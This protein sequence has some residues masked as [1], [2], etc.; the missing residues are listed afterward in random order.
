MKK[1]TLRLTL[2]FAF[3]GITLFSF[4]AVKS[5]AMETRT[6][7]SINVSFD[8]NAKTL[9][10]NE[11]IIYTNNYGVDLNKLVLHLY[12]N[13]YKT[14]STLPSIG[15]QNSNLSEDQ[16]GYIKI[17]EVHVDN[18]AMPF[19]SDNQI[20]KIS[21]DSPLESGH[22]VTLK[23]SFIVKIPAGTD[24]LGYNNDVYSITNWY[25]IM[26]IYDKETNSWDENEFNPVGESNYSDTSDYSFTLVTPKDIVTAATGGILNETISG[27]IK[28][29]NA[30]AY[31]VRDF[32]FMMSRY[33]RI[34]STTSNGVKFKS[35]YIYDDNSKDTEPTAKALMDV[36]IKAEK[37]YSESYGKYPYP[38]LDMVETYLSGGAMEYP[39]LIQMGKYQPLSMENFNNHS[40]WIEDA[41]AHETGHQWWYVA[42]GNNEFKEPVM[43]ESLNTFSTAYFF[44][45]EYGKY[46][47]SGITMK[48]RNNLV[49]G[50]TL[51]INSSVD[52][53]S[54]WDDYQTVIYQKGPE[55][56]EDLREKVGD[57]K[58]LKILRT[59]F[60]KFEFK[61]GSIKDF[62]NVIGDVAGSAA[63]SYFMQSA[64]SSSYY[65]SSIATTSS[66]K[67][68]IDNLDIINDLQSRENNKGMTIG[69]ILLRGM[70]NEPIDIIIPS[71]LT[72]ADQKNVSTF[73]NLLKADLKA[74]YD[75]NVNILNDSNAKSVEGKDNIIVLGNP[76]N[77]LILREESSRLPLKI[78]N[79]E[80][81]IKNYK[82][83]S[84]NLSGVYI[85][86]NPRNT[87]K[88]ML[89]IYWKDSFYKYYI[90]D[91]NIDQYIINYDDGKELRGM[92]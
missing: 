11:S 36:M 30:S 6:K 72:V 37:F 48:I 43:D 50:N 90:L 28:T 13:S 9:S 25:P 27:N 40:T 21:L 4:Y 47:P 60:S 14:S 79:K 63:Q 68:H 83:S 62:E 85:I 15:N 42:V 49:G 7:Y 91:D 26:S 80:A 44:E 77:N 33:F 76:N 57:E 74:Y 64:A 39:A 87:N 23:I 19:T 81:L 2:L 82:V 16:A 89:V 58:F 86:K 22:E 17:S 32:V 65:P 88:L 52:K 5:S 75:I 10:G 84:K 38:E 3:I 41:A 20:L 54:N 51:P 71:K 46:T 53:F 67:R 92:L 56:F 18:K 8:E 61:N 69:S 59:Y 34:L 78:N 45:K 66:E 70:N 12:P 35:Y 73:V 29:V 55:L 31:N 1:F 24:R